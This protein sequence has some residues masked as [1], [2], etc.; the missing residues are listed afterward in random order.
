MILF[1][2][3]SMPYNDFTN[4]CWTLSLKIESKS[5]QKYDSSFEC[6]QLPMKGPAPEGACYAESTVIVGDRLFCGSI[7]KDEESANRALLA[8]PSQQDME[9]VVAQTHGELD[10]ILQNRLNAER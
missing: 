3:V 7:K 10:Q 6:C 8:G 1:G 9:E 4:D 2:G 5:E